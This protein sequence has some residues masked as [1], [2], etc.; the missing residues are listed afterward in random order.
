MTT[1][2]LALGALGVVALVFGLLVDDLDVDLGPDWISLPVI[3]SLL[4][5]FGFVGAA[6]SA[7][8]A[9]TPV[10]LALGTATG[11]ALAVAA[12]RLIRAL[13]DMPTD[14]TMRSSDMVGRPGRVVTA[15]TAERT[16][17]VLV[18]HAGQRLKVAAR[19]DEVLPVGAQVVVVEVLS[20]TLVVVESHERFWSADSSPPPSLPPTP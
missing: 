13:M 9:P 2:L 10:A 14:S 20:P 6:A 1:V 15:L 3:A 4:G 18:D 16:G 12:S 8:G 19:G 11:I 5:A 17:E 7:F